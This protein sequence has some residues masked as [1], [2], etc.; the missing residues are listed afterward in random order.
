MLTT[1]LSPLLAAFRCSGDASLLAL[2]DSHLLLR[3]GFG[4]DRVAPPDHD[5]RHP[6]LPDLLEDRDPADPQRLAGVGCREEL[7]Q[8]AEKVSQ[9]GFA[10]R[11]NDDYLVELYGELS[12]DHERTDNGFAKSRSYTFTP[13]LRC[14]AMARR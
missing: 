5:R 6:A 1:V 4:G 9:R 13:L 10:T 11:E 3:E 12:T 2:G 7:L 14:D 8:E